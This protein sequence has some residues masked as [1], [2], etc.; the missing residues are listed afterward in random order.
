MT[1]DEMTDEQVMRTVTVA[2]AAVAGPCSTVGGLITTAGNAANFQIGFEVPNIWGYENA[3]ELIASAGDCSIDTVAGKAY[4]WK[5]A[6][7]TMSTADS[8]L[9]VLIFAGICTK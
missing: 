3:R 2:I 5:R 9:P 6:G 7:D 8:R 1:P 4:Y